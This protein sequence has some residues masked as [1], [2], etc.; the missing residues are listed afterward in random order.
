M[1]KKKTGTDNIRTGQNYFYFYMY[2]ILLHNNSSTAV[3]RNR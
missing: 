2:T 3:V 1:R